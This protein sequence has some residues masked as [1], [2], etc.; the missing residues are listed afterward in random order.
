M[1]CMG[2]GGCLY[3]TILTSQI[4]S[5]FIGVVPSIMCLNYNE[6]IWLHLS[7][8]RLLCIRINR[9]IR[10]TVLLI[11]II[12]ITKSEDLK[13]LSFFALPGNVWISHG[14][15]NRGKHRMFE[16]RNLKNVSITRMHRL[17]C[18]NFTKTK[19]RNT[20][21]CERSANTDSLTGPRYENCG[22]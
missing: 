15:K 11:R 19:I 22:A 3:N 12:I 6:E 10:I 5:T 21:Q 17:P 8:L 2:R 16:H 18:L 1:L 7:S 9:I 13:Y 20:S 14:T 4:H